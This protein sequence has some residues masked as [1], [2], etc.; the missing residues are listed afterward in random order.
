VIDDFSDLL[1]KYKTSSI[2]IDNHTKLVEVSPLGSR[3]FLPDDDP[4][5]LPPVL[6]NPSLAPVQV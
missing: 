3:E 4:I 5:L 1:I 6:G 2:S